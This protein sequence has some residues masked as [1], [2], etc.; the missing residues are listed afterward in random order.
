[1]QQKKFNIIVL[2]MT[3]INCYSQNTI[4]PFFPTTNANWIEAEIYD[5]GQGPVYKF[6]QFYLFGDTIINQKKFTKLFHID[7]N[8]IKELY[9]WIIIDS[10]NKQVVYRS[11]HK[12]P[13]EFPRCNFESEYLL[14]DFS[15]KSE[16]KY[17]QYYCDKDSE[18]IK[19]IDTINNHG[20]IYRRLY[21]ESSILG[22]YWFE[23]IGS[24]RGLLAPVT[25]ILID[26]DYRRNELVCFKQNDTLKFL[27]SAYLDCQSPI[28]S[29]NKYLKS[30]I[31]HI[32]IPNPANDLNQIRS[33]LIYQLESYQIYNSFSYLIESYHFTGFSDF[34]VTELQFGIYY[35]KEKYKNGEVFVEKIIFIK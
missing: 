7:S 33:C 34:Q 9:G 18:I 32:V 12:H 15:Y 20:N 5:Y 3:I 24:S 14:Y 10:N 19:K 29:I 1:M 4:Q 25:K 11:N 17:I 22:N 8:G 27:N 26:K 16:G 31:Q 13:L 30:R 35:I 23:G 2:F 6:Y 21:L 28:T